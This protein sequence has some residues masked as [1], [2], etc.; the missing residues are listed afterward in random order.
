MKSNER[1]SSP[2]TPSQVNSTPQGHGQVSV[3]PASPTAARVARAENAGYND[4]YVQGRVVENVR[5]NQLRERDNDNSARGLFLG[6]ILTSLAA[7]AAGTLYYLSDRDGASTPVTTPVP[8]QIEAEPAPTRTI[9]RERT[10]IERVIPVPQDTSGEQEQPASEPAPAEP[11]PNINITVP[12]SQTQEAPAEPP[13]PAPAAPSNI[14]IN[15]PEIK[16]DSTP[17]A[18]AE[19]PEPATPPVESQQAPETPAET[20]P[21]P[22]SAEPSNEWGSAIPAN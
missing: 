5:E 3:P 10:L 6:I 1:Q 2:Q 17:A 8:Q 16:P 15:L 13:A 19:S 9:E 18:P 22:Q 11:A 7:L 12:N 21:E 20:A 4:G 14:N